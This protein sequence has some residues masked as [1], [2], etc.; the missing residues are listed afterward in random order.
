MLAYRIV[1]DFGIANGRCLLI[2]RGDGPLEQALQQGLA[3]VTAF[4]I[5]V[6]Y[7]TEQ[8]AQTARARLGEAKLTARIACEVGAIPSLPFAAS[9]FDVVASVGT[10]P[11][12]PDRVAA[13]REIHR[14]LRPGGAALVGG[15]YRFMPDKIK[16]STETLRHE[17]TRSE[18]ASIRVYD[19][20]G[21]W[22]EIRKPPKP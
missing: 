11:F 21:Q 14:V 7:P 12:W 1:A 18:I 2:C 15:L 5:T 17:A 8:L 20:R 19:D 22:V 10:V 3:D 16:V 9:R 4:Q 6:L 13:F